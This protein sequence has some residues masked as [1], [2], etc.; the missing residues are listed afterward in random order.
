MRAPRLRGRTFVVYYGYGPLSE[1]EAYDIAILE[2]AGWRAEDMQVLGRRG[3]Q[4]IAYLSAL[5]ATR[6]TLTR[7]GV[8]AQQLL[9]VEGE[10]W[11]RRSFGTY[12]VDPRSRLWRAHVVAQARRLVEEGWDGIFLDSLGDV[13]DQMVQD[14]SGWLLPAAA[15]LVGEVR[16]AIGDHLL[17]QNNGIFLLLPLVASLIDGI[18][19]EGSFEPEATGGA[20][21]RMVLE[22]IANVVHQEGITPM[23]LSEIGDS[24]PAAASLQILDGMAER[25][26]FLSYAAPLDYA[27]GIR[28]LDGRVVL[29]QQSQI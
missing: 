3:V 11:L 17:L 21:L 7:L 26:G 28:T 12:V 9:H 14:R 8:P 19:W 5:E 18:C 1:L 13:E 20:W 10:P 16:A 27:Q 6:E 29:G 2:P 25:Y 23:L 22:Q 15:N 4:R 24:A